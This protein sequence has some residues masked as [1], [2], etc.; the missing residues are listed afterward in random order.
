MQHIYPPWTWIVKRLLY[1]VVAAVLFGCLLSLVMAGARPSEINGPAWAAPTAMTLRQVSTTTGAQNEPNFLDN[2]DCS[3]VSYRLVSSGT[4]ENGCFSNSAFGLMDSSASRVIFNGTDEA[5]PLLS[6]VSHQVLVPWPN[7]LELV[8]LDAVSTGGSYISLYSNPLI[9]LQDQRNLIGQLISKRLTAPPDI[10][11][12]DPS[13]QRLVI[14]AQTLAFSAS[15]SWLVAETVNGSFIRINLATHD[16][17]AFAKSYTTSGSPGALPSRVAITDDGRFVAISND[18]STEFKVHDLDSCNGVINNLQPQLCK[19][20]DY[21]S[22]AASQ[23]SGLRYIRHVRFV[24]NNLLSFETRT[25]GAD[26]GGIYMLTPA[27]KMDFLSDYIGLGDSYTSGEGAYNY[28]PG[29]DD[30]DNMCH[31]SRHSYT[32]LLTSELFSATGGHS[33]ACSGAVINDVGSTSENYRGQ[34][35]G[36]ANW[37]QLQQTE[38]QLLK[39]VVTNFLPGYMAQ[40]RF[41]QHW[42]PRI[43]TVSAGGNDVGFGAILE[44]CVVP[45]V[46]RHFSDNTCFN[47]YE[48]RLEVQHL[49]DRTVPRLT[50]LYRQL[51]RQAPRTVIYSIG[52]PQI[53]DDTGKCGVNVQLNKSELEFAA[54]LID[55]LNLSIEKAA[56]AANVTYVDISQALAG[57]RLCE[58]A[59]FAVAVNGITAGKDGGPFGTKL[60]GKESYHPNALGHLLIKQAILR[61]T[62]NF[63]DTTKKN[64]MHPG[65]T[66]SRLLAG[67]QTGRQV[68]VRIPDIKLT[69]SV[70][71]RGNSITFQ[72]K[73][74]AHGLKPG[75]AYTIRIDGPDGPI[76]G[77][78]MSNAS[79]DIS[80]SASIAET[81]NPGGHTIDVT[82]VNQIGEPVNIT[83]PIYVLASETDADG[84]GIPNDLDTCPGAINTKLDSDSD[85]TDDICDNL[86]GEQFSLPG[87]TG[88]GAVSTDDGPVTSNTLT[89]TSPTVAGMLNAAKITS[90]GLS[91]AGTSRVLGSATVNPHITPVKLPRLAEKITKNSV[92]AQQ[93]Q[94]VKVINWLPW[95]ITPST[96]WWLLM[97]GLYVYWLSQRRNYIVCNTSPR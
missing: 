44:S 88:G 84:D 73:G 64:G 16:V 78:T 8:A 13:G 20:F 51:Q 14:N 1:L 5:L 39:S 37:R 11:L 47:T 55:Y 83:Q 66:G 31:L 93:S 96:V 9:Y 19:S 62:R 29:T 89:P 3:L 53:A 45:R 81:V 12:R 80:A 82:G 52:Y 28:L 69:G 32:L 70:A 27:D 58:T 40:H 61:Q 21:R 34:V 41:V 91:L 26:S 75:T 54:S 30:T 77:K 85:G 76:I 65:N 90:K 17:M 63:T 60:F 46:S 42:Q 95:I 57:H 36:V 6:P 15:G 35:R 86:I 7:A 24:N 18:F 23:I 50:T 87:N 97:L 38:P 22:F 49:I 48:D 25:T 71:K 56:A 68:Y 43:I 10:L 59:S 4:M 92:A 74:A 33:V 94:T 79:G 72:A 2:L 67:P